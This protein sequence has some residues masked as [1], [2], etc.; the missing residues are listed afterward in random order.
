MEPTTFFWDSENTEMYKQITAALE[1]YF[2]RHSRSQQ[3]TFQQRFERDMSLM[4]PETVNRL[5]R[6]TELEFEFD[7]EHLDAYIHRLR[8][9]SN[10]V[11][12]ASPHQGKLWVKAIKDDDCLVG[13]DSPMKCGWVDVGS[14]SWVGVESRLPDASD[15]PYGLLKVLSHG[16]KYCIS[17]LC[18]PESLLDDALTRAIEQ[19]NYRA[20]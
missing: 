12:T 1:E 17:P 13:F 20:E 4:G 15:H 18:F 10:G 7:R 5:L 8:C 11:E 14:I 2:K 6:D 19:L 9:G 16:N 3:M